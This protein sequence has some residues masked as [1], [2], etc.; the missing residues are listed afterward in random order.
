MDGDT[1]HIFVVFDEPQRWTKGNKNPAIVALMNTIATQGRA[2][3]LHFLVGTQKPLV[4]VFGDS[5]TADQ[6]SGA[7]GFRVKSYQASAAI[8]GG[9]KP[10]ADTLLPAGD[11]Y[12]VAASPRT[13][14]ERVQVAYIPEDELARIGGGQPMLDE[15]PEYDVAGLDQ[16][17]SGRPPKCTTPQEIAHGL[18]TVAL[19]RGRPYFRELFENGN[20]PGASRSRRILGECREIVEIM[21][22][23]G[24]SYGAT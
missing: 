24:L 19:G 7:V 21:R 11:A 8:F 18:E 13:V 1:P 22:E 12:V 3:G 4:G 16:K 15:W 14:Q 10:R 6:F 2:A 9:P 5:T 17:A 20:T 23:R